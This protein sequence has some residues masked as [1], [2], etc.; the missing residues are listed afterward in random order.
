MSSTMPKKK[1]IA[2]FKAAVQAHGK[3]AGRHTLPWRTNPSP[4]RVLVSE[5]MLQQTQVERVVPKFQA[6]MRA[7]P[8]W[9]V[10]AQAT[11]RRVYALWRGL[12]YNRRA[13]YLRD[14]AKRVVA[15]GVLLNDEAFI[16]TL[17]G[18]GPYTAGAIRAFAFGSSE[19]FIETNIRTAVTHHF[20]PGTRTVRDAEVL[21]VLERLRPRN[22]AAARDWYAALMDYG[23]H[24]KRSGVRLNVRAHGYA[25]QS[26]FEGSLRQLRGAIV[27]ELAEGGAGE[28][29]LVKR[30]KRKAVEV[31]KALAGLTRDGLIEKK[32]KAYCLAA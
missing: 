6:F 19:P 28:V 18:V 16:R 32:G 10:L 27:R 3:A 25:K 9:R 4:Y 21:A 30:T 17:P 13:K 15:H 26:K 23:A 12:G 31:K 24:L 2:R 14:A 8:D 1:S 20:F 11:L 22:G 5:Y 29:A 7:F